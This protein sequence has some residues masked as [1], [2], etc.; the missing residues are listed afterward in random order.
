MSVWRRGIWRNWS[1]MIIGWIHNG[2]RQGRG[3]LC[4]D[5][6]LC[7]GPRSASCC[8]GIC[9]SVISHSSFVV[10]CHCHGLLLMG[11]KRGDMHVATGRRM[12]FKTIV[13][14]RHYLLIL[15]GRRSDYRNISWCRRVHGSGRSCLLLLSDLL[16]SSILIHGNRLLSIR[17]MT[18]KQRS[19]TMCICPVSEVE[20]RRRCEY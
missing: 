3:H 17:S 13:T 8:G 14:I 18:W 19:K 9:S 7:C 1:R 11:K 4:R 16:L 2:R 10:L 6:N 5:S 12:H 15:T 20:H